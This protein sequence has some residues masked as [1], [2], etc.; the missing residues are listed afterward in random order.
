MISPL[1]VKLIGSMYGIFTY[2]VGGFNPFEKYSSNWVHLPQNE[3]ENK[4]IFESTNR[5]P[6]GMSMVLSNW[7]ITPI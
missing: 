3:G 7:V 2:L 4:N 1:W 5:L 6:T